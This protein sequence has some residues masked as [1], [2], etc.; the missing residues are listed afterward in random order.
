MNFVVLFFIL[1]VPYITSAITDQIYQKDEKRLT[2]PEFT[3]LPFLLLKLTNVKFI[4]YSD[5][6][7]FHLK[8]IIEVLQ[9]PFVDIMDVVNVVDILSLNENINPIRNGKEKL[10]ERISVAKQMYGL[11]WDNVGL[12]GNCEYFKVSSFHFTI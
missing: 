4:F 5:L 6:L 8:L 3:I 7:N 11:V 10:I 1:M 9:K 2:R 12:F